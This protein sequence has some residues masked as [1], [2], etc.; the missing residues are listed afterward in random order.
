[1]V[2]P[3]FDLRSIFGVAP[4]PTCSNS[5]MVFTVTGTVSNKTDLAYQE[6]IVREKLY[7]E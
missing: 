1:M 5:G 2:V 4:C 3:P 6:E 7:G